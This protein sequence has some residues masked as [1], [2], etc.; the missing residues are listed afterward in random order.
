MVNRPRR[1]RTRVPKLVFDPTRNV[2]WHVSYRDPRTGHSHRHRFGVTE[3]ERE[4]D[5]LGLYHAWVAERLGGNTEKNLPTKVEPAKKPRPT[6]KA[7]SGSLLEV[8]SS[9]KESE[10][11]RIRKPEESRRRGTIAAPVFRDRAKVIRDFLEFIN[12]RNGPGA[13]SRMRLVDLTMDDVEAFNQH[14]VKAGFSDSQVAKR[15]QIVKAI[16]DR[17][18]RPENGRQMLTWNWDSRDVAHGKPT[19]ERPL[20]SVELLKKML[21]GADLRGK[22]MIWLGIGLGLGAKDLAVVRI[23][24]IDQDAYDLRRS[25]TGVERFGTTPPRVWACVSRY[26][27]STKR[28][29][30]ELL[31]VTRTGVPLVHARGNSVTLWWDRLRTK[32]GES[33]KTIPGFYTLR[34]LGA[35]EFGSRPGTSISDAKRWLG[36]ASSSDMADVYMRPV[37]PE[38]KKVVEWVRTELNRDSAD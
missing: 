35:T 34:H 14:V 17:A 20:P 11:Q 30:G 21:A 4:K 31:F 29:A 8:A 18:G 2:G 12:A 23:G 22:T 25:K 27:A 26:Q 19:P 37:R 7:L 33:K 28:P 3:R 16:I 5:A 10:R 36:H 24:Q 38:F 32:V 1:K 9:L 13:V 15:L 6:G